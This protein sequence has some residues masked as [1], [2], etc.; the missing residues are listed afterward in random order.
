MIIHLLT[1]L[2]ALVL[3]IT[4]ANRSIV[5]A[6]S[7]ARHLNWSPLLIGLTIVSLG[8]SLPEILIA[9]L[10]AQAGYPDLALGNIIGSNIANIGL[11]L[12]ITAVVMP[13]TLQSDL[14]KRELPLL[15]AFALIDYC[16]I[17]DGLGRGDSFLMLIVLLTFMI[18]QI[19]TA[20][21]QEFEGTFEK[22]LKTA[23]PD[24]VP[25]KKAAL[26][27]GFGLI[28]LAVSAK[29]LVWSATNVA[30]LLGIEEWI[31][32]LTAI[33]ISSSL[34]ELAISISSVLKKED[35][36][37]VGNIIGSSI[38]NLLLAYPLSGLITPERML[39]IALKRDF[40]VMLGFTSLLFFL[41]RGFGSNQGGINRWEGGILLLAYGS[42]LWF[43][44][45]S[46]VTF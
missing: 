10:A 23:L 40:P 30:H 21:Q 2:G 26:Y 28:I 34:P 13:L 18:W 39:D 15:L 6:A 9:I 29:L 14:L 5:G 45:Q 11:V 22:E 4:A 20:Q 46:V 44:Y 33:A 36:L 42:Y 24:T 32:G 1:L 27:L 17:F 7:I 3:L 41:G 43:I 8:T 25:F 12:G 38:Y 37:A 31:I 16:V 35:D 19:R